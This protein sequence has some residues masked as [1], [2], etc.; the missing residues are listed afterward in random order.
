MDSQNFKV[1]SLYNTKS[2]K[3]VK[4]VIRSDDTV[5]G[6]DGIWRYDRE[7]DTGR[8]TGTNHDG[9][10]HLNLVIGEVDPLFGAGMNP[11]H[12]D[13][14][15]QL[16]TTLQDQRGEL[17]AALNELREQSMAG[18]SVFKRLVKLGLLDKKED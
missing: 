11:D 7:G 3:L 14:I 5:C 13:D 18:N 4:I 10:Y 17:R 9:S 8:V 6:N 12:K 2:G 15:L 1:G 16:I